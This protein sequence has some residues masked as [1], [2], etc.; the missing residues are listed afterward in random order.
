M[1]TP[2]AGLD[3]KTIFKAYNKNF[4]ELTVKG[5]KPKLNIIDNQATKYIKK[6][7]S[8]NKCELQLVEPHNHRVNATERAIQTLKDTFIAALASTD[9]DFP[10]Q[11]W[12]KLTPQ[13]QNCLNLMRR[14]Q[15]NWA[16]SAYKAMNGPYDW[17]QYPLASLGCK[18]VVYKDGDT[19]GSWAS[20]GINGWYL[21]PSMDPYQ[22][23]LYFIPEKRAY[24]ISGSTELFPQ[25]CQLPNLTQHQHFRALTNKLADFTAIASA[26][27]KGRGLIK[28][29]HNIITKNLNPPDILEEQRMNKQMMN[30]E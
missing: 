21:G 11:L 19:R 23:D 5:F 16:I 18:A 26:T 1:A 15:I 30:K 13:V 27:P 24:Q 29:L 25:H 12:D 17:N 10:I 4:N 8:K 3:N 28:L 22:C 6:I 7:L 14:S 20:R 2:I 9:V